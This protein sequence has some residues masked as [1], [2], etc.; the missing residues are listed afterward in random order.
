M[1]RPVIGGTRNAGCQGVRPTTRAPAISSAAAFA[2]SAVAKTWRPVTSQ[3]CR[4]VVSVRSLTRH[5]VGVV[6]RHRGAA[7]RHHQPV[8]H[9]LVVRLVKQPDRLP[10]LALALVRVA[11][12]IE[13]RG[14]NAGPVGEVLEPAGERARTGV[15]KRQLPVDEHVARAI[16]REHV[17]RLGFVGGGIERRR[18]RR[19]DLRRVRDGHAAAGLHDPVALVPPVHH[20]VARGRIGVAVP[21]G[22]RCAS[23][24]N[25]SGVDVRN[26]AMASAQ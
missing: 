18:V 17:Q 19:P 5:D 21:R 11:Q 2:A 25:G 12:R 9:R 4:P 3:N 6:R 24:P 14:R 15:A 22:S 23:E 13:T 20:R 10:R 8:H 1:R 26:H 7:A 16:R